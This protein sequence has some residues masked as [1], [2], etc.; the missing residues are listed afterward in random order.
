MVRTDSLKGR[1]GRLP[2]KSKNTEEVSSNGALSLTKALVQAF[3]SCGE[4][5]PDHSP[6][7]SIGNSDQLIDSINASLRNVQR[8]AEKIPGWSK[9]TL[10]DR[11]TL[12]ENGTVNVLSLRLAYL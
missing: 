3:T 5:S 1:R 2:S 10:L 12:I 11:K 4:S 7:Q 8:W 9:L 6:V